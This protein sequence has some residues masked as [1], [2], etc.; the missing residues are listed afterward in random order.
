VPPDCTR[1]IWGK[2]D[3]IGSVYC[4]FFQLSLLIALIA[5]CGEGGAQLDARVL[6]LSVDYSAQGPTMAR[7]TGE[8]GAATAGATIECRLATGGKPSLGETTANEFGAFEM[9]LD[10]AAFPQRVPVG[11]EFRAFN[12]TVECRPRGGSWVSPLRQPVLRIA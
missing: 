6:Q 12:E 7:M 5:A 2:N 4:K 10:H 3:I 11:D 1:R 8:R 9:T